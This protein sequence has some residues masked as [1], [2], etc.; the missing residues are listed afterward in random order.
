MGL[1]KSLA[2]AQS[3][4]G[5]AMAMAMAQTGTETQTFTPANDLKLPYSLDATS[6]MV[7]V[8][9]KKPSIVLENLPSFSDVKCADGNVIL[10]FKNAEA[11]K[12]ARNAWPSSGDFII[13]MDE[14]PGT[15]SGDRERG[16]F[17]L[18]EL[19][20]DEEKFTITA[21]AQKRDPKDEVEDAVIHFTRTTEVAAE[22]TTQLVARGGRKTLKIGPKTFKVD[23]SNKTLINTKPLY[24]HMDRARFTST[25][26]IEGHVHFNLAKM[27]LKE[28]N[29]QLTLDYD[30]DLNVTTRF[31]GRIPLDAISQSPL[32][33][34]ISAIHIPGILNIGP[35]A[36]VSLGVETAAEG[37]VNVTAVYRSTMKG[38][39]AR[40]DLLDKKGSKA[41]GWKPKT[42]GSA[43]VS[44]RL[45]LQLNPFVDFTVEFAIR[46]FG[47]LMDLGSGITVRPTLVNA[48]V[49][50]SNYT[51][52]ETGIELT[53]PKCPDSAAKGSCCFNSAWYESR[54]W[55]EVRAFVTTFYR[56]P[57]YKVNVPIYKGECW[58]LDKSAH[59][60]AVY[61]NATKAGN[62]TGVVQ[63]PKPRKRSNIFEST[64]LYKA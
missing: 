45:Q 55:F 16:F 47:G 64:H 40:L 5:L 13:V 3:L 46:V 34:G 54:F 10:S 18:G 4:I 19:S 41:E 22:E 42:T 12:A 61:A 35:R 62:W 29:L 2:I 21:A 9:M 32:V 56:I 49:I 53:G 31:N 14:A 11:V 23:L 8:V 43:D 48:Y 20:H 51:Q 25:V 57:L 44:T 26:Q 37:P 39:T 28:F 6:A 50:G 33:A 52:N 58:P 63:K 1:L 60:L 24:I 30:L 36:A 27:K 38:A 59:A 7:S 17:L 15:C